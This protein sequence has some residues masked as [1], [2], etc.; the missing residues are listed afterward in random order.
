MLHGF[1]FLFLAAELVWVASAAPGSL[2]FLGYPT[3]S[4]GL[5]GVAY[6]AGVPA[7]FGKR[8]DGKYSPLMFVL[9]L[10]FHGVAALSAVLRGFRRTKPSHE[11]MPGLWL[12]ARTHELP[13]G[14]ERIVDLTV[15]HTRIGPDVDYIL[16]PTLDAQPPD[17]D[18]M[19]A[20]ID[21][22]VADP[23]TTYVHCFAGR[24]RSATFVAAYLLR[25]DVVSTVEEAETFMKQRREVVSL[26]NAQRH[27]AR[28]F[29]PTDY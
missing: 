28:R 24:G 22:M 10:P 17:E 7:L 14:I 6:L 26:G 20:A 3:L 15:E 13:D 16:I 25:T 8:A 1:A 18:A 29:E 19:R 5:V 21:R 4:F 12:G 11:I 27:V 2:W 9:H 23:K